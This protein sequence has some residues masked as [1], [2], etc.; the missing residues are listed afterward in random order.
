M[1]RQQEQLQRLVVPRNGLRGALEFVYEAA[2]NETERFRNET[3]RIQQ[4]VA[5][6]E[7]FHSAR[8]TRPGDEEAA[9]KQDEDEDEATRMPPEQRAMYF[10]PVSVTLYCVMILVIESLLIHT[11]LT[12]SRNAEELAGYTTDS[13][14]TET[15]S[16]ASRSTSF[17]PM[18]CLLFVACRMYVLATTEGQG[19][20]PVWVKVCMVVATVGM[21]FQFL[22][23]LMLPMATEQRP[24]YGLRLTEMA[25][26]PSD[27]HPMLWAHRYRN[28]GLRSFMYSTQG[29]ALVC[30][31]GGVLGVIAGIVTFPKGTTEVSA[32]VKCTVLLSLV[33]FGANLAQWALRTHS[34]LHGFLDGTWK[35][36]R[37]GAL[38]ASMS[39]RKVPMF[40][41]IFLAARMRALQLDPPHGLPPVW[42]Q[43]CFYTIVA[44]IYCEVAACVYIGA[45]GEEEEGR[46]YSGSYVFTTTSLG[47]N[48]VQHICALL[49]TAALVPV[50]LA[51]FWME[52]ADGHIAP[53]SRTVKSALEL[54][55]LFFGVHTLQTFVALYESVFR[56]SCPKWRNTLLAT[57]QGVNMCPL[58]SI[59]FLATRMRA[60]QITNQQGTVPGWAQHCMA[61]CVFATVTQFLCCLVLPL[62]TGKAAK[63]D[64]DGAPQYDLSP[65]VR[66]YAVTVVKYVALICLHGGVIGVCFAV[67]AMTPETA[68]ASSSEAKN[69]RRGILQALAVSLVVVGISM[70][71]SS[72][73]VIGMGVKMAI[74]S[75]DETLLGVQ[76][77]VGKAMLDLCSGSV[78]ISH[79]VVHNPKPK[80]G[81]PEWESPYLLRVD[82][83]CVDLHTTKMLRSLGKVF[84]V[85]QLRLEGVDVCFE[86]PS[87]KAIANVQQVVE[88]LTNLAE[89]VQ[90]TVGISA[91]G[92]ERQ[93]G[94]D[95]QPAET[96]PLPPPASPPPPATE[97][98]ESMPEVIVEEV[99]I[100]DIGAGAWFSGIL[101][102]A[103]LEDI[104]YQ[105]FH[106]QFM[107]NTGNAVSDVVKVIVMTFLKTVLANKHLMRQGL[108]VAGQAMLGSIGLS[109][110]KNK[111]GADAGEEQEEDALRPPALA[112]RT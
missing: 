45:N 56:K 110:N 33:Y 13:L 71:L 2:A 17:P 52:G 39:T 112:M 31:Y 87:L 106:E 64:E 60:L 105:N 94:A 43:A 5:R 4:V 89:Q 57:A 58:L 67:F 62:F 82:R 80:P 77:T 88:H 35:S 36:V 76:I 55:G 3:F 95:Q 41:V 93:E 22:V 28:V 103:A 83:V 68:V 107:Q 19:E 98:A 92:G 79:I 34:E 91:D 14:V 59:L 74:E 9:S 11:F 32:A 42:A 111:D 27:V 109:K 53:L 108:K 46:E 12:V 81:A 10:R 49:S 7:L 54:G 65:M 72:A 104:Q 25:G 86:K 51:I 23:V 16:C 101:V 47:S 48:L 96:P 50:V 6:T 99:S 61:M 15:L 69:V 40:A 90:E 100:C 78:S 37:N 20:P 75:V 21:T 102:K 84:E 18:L 1:L 73:K 38:A 66:A 70:A 30:I 44:L 97:D 24:H 63:V 85:N 8:L 26:E 29:V